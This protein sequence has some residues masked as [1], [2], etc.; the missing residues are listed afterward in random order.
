MSGHSPTLGLALAVAGAGAL[1]ALLRTFLNDAIAHR[2]RSD[3]PFGILSVNVS[4]SF[5]LG[6]LTGLSWYH[7]LPAD[8]VVVAG[9]GLCGGFT[10]WSTAIWETL[11][12]LRL[13]RL[14]QAASYTLGGLAMAVGAAGLGIGLAALA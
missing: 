1:G 5:L 6:L 2:V 4:G 3:F 12:L 10:T 11:A 8:V 7:G 9:V 14:G 13:G